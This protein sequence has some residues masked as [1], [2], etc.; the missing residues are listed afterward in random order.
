MKQIVR[1]GLAD[2]VRAV[3]EENFAERGELGASVSVWLEGEELVSLSSGWC[4][5]EQQRPWTERSLA[6]VYS[7]TKGP[8][9]ATFL[10]VLEEAGLSPDAWV[11]SVWPEL[12]AGRIG[13]LTFLELL[14]HQAGLPGIANQTSVADR[15]AVV[16]GLEETAPYWEPGEGH[17]YHARTIGFC[18]DELCQRI[19]GCRLGE[20]F[21]QWIGG[22]LELDFWIGLP[23]EENDR[24]ATLYPGRY[25]V[26]KEEK[27][28]YQAMQTEGSLSR[29]AFTSLKGFQSA[30][31][32]NDPE[33][34]AGGF[35]AFGGVGSA[36][37]LARFY[38]AVLGYGEVIPA[39]VGRL[40][41]ERVVEGPDQVLRVATSFAAG[42]MMDARD[43]SGKKRRQL[44]GPNDEAFGHPGAGGSHAFCDPATGVSF[45]YVMNQM[46]LGVLPGER[47]L[48]L[49]K[50][51]YA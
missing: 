45:A 2:R 6:P 5:R 49:V 37:A 3:F 24:V 16:R 20:C 4:E 1:D 22:P 38:Q 19:L 42:M 18:L 33:A 28:F 34:W 14:S 40:L 8:A 30:G 32:M 23:A 13:D 11:R 47:A 21:Q 43:D 17:G 27:E 7:S 9:A 46:E 51:I 39:S 25:L 10:M 48:G 44:F 31:E 26:R 41:G 36:A 29:R 12:G 35:P 50:A 15:E